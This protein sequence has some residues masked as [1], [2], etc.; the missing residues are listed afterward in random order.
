MI[1][2]TKNVKKRKQEYYKINKENI[3]RRNKEWHKSHKEQHSIR[4]KKW[5]RENK[6][7]HL[8]NYS[9]WAKE[10]REELNAY[11]RKWGRE[12]RE[13]KMIFS[14]TKYDKKKGFICD[15]S[16]VWIKNNITSKPCTYCGS[17]VGIGCDR[18]DNSMGHLKINVIPC[19]RQCNSIRNNFFTVEEMLLLG[20]TIKR[21]KS[22]R[23]K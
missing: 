14:Y 5:Y 12:N 1:K 6:K 2:R 4:T 19:C 17:V 8:M 21:I 15:L 13:K 23:K 3:D 7:R 11:N 20:K 22:K 9:K 10:H 18:I 16:E